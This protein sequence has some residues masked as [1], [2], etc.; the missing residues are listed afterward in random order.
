VAE[1]AVDLCEH[2]LGRARHPG[3]TRERPVFGGDIDSLDAFWADA[4]DSGGGAGRT[5]PPPVLGRLKALYG[6]EHGDV[7]SLAADCPPLAQPL[8]D[9][10]TTIGAQVVHAARHEMARRLEDVVLRRTEL[11]TAGHPGDAALEAAA[12]IAAGELGWSAERT[13]AEVAAVRAL[14]DE[15]AR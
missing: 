10:C 8:A 11:G 1:R 9:G 5:L 14:Y 4:D 13:R 3:G 7:L 15:F 2:Q 12:R 6:T